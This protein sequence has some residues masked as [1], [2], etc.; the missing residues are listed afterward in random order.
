M[1]IIPSEASDFVAS[2]FVRFCCIILMASA[3][4]STDPSMAASNTYMKC[5]AHTRLPCECEGF[6]RTDLNIREGMVLSSQE[7]IPYQFSPN[8]ELYF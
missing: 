1:E 8:G 5:I 6:L 4:L 2:I 3:S 7:S